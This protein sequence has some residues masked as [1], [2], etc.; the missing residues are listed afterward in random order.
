ME[1]LPTSAV[2]ML[3]L[4]VVSLLAG[5]WTNHIAYDGGKSDKMEPHSGEWVDLVDING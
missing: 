4:I 1:T 5:A 3:I 2:A